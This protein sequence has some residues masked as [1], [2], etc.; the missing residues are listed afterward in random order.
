MTSNLCILICCLYLLCTLKLQ[1]VFPCNSS[2][3]RLSPCRIS[4]RIHV[5][6]VETALHLNQD[7]PFIAM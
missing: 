4:T 3:P 5:H 1:L 2:S 7:I 6:K